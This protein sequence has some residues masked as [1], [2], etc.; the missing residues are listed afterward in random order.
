MPVV[1]RVEIEDDVA[2]AP[3]E[4]DQRAKVVAKLEK[5]TGR[6]I[7]PDFQIDPHLIGGIHVEY[8]NFLLDSSLRGELRRLR[9]RL[10]LDVLKQS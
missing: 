1:V 3:L 8:E 7:E 6:K 2:G 10:L 4:D 9:E 5:V